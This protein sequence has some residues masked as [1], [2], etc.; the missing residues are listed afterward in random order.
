MVRVGGPWAPSSGRRCLGVELLDLD[1]AALL[2]DVGLLEVG[3]VA[4]RV[5]SVAKPAEFQYADVFG[6]SSGEED[7]RYRWSQRFQKAAVD[8]HPG[9]SAYTL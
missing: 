9:A 5:R 3:S 6:Q 7:V 8:S 4:S 2:C 1:W